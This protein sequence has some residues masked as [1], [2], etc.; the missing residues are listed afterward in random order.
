MPRGRPPYP[1]VLT[2]RE[3]EVLA[4]IRE[5]LTNPQI[6]QRLGVSESAAKFHVSEILSKLGVESRQEAAGFSA[7]PRPRWLLFPRLTFPESWKAAA[8]KWL[9][10][11]VIGAAAV[12]VI[13]I[14]AIVAGV[15]ILEDGSG[16]D[17]AAPPATADLQD[18]LGPDLPAEPTATS[19]PAASAPPEEAIYW[20]LDHHS[21]GTPSQT[22]LRLY[23]FALPG[24]A[25][26]VTLRAPDG[27]TAGRAPIMG[28]GIFGEAS[29]VSR[30][31][32][33]WPGLITVVG[34]V[35]EMTADALAAF[36]AN[37]GA[38]RAEVDQRDLGMTNPKQFD[39]P[40][41][42]TGCRPP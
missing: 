11:P 42:D 41:V 34:P 7:S 29:C 30:V 31:S 18:A 6:A 9:A 28:S 4:L 36:L 23:L 15:I 33:D 24:E 25:G 8:S 37:P 19:V 2:P 13:A 20:A 12:V 40:L 5:G 32:K 1:D 21:D 38:Y 26:V 17:D 16:G 3:W 35:F 27:S 14:L 10:P 39:L 22:R